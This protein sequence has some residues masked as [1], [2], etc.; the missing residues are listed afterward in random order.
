MNTRK[1]KTPFLVG[2]RN[3]IVHAVVCGA[4]LVLLRTPRAEAE[5]AP[6]HYA[7]KGTGSCASSVCHGSATARAG[8][9]ILHNEYVTWLKRDKHS[10]AWVALASTDGKRIGENLGIA[11]PEKEPLCLT[12][13]ATYNSSVPTNSDQLKDGVGC[14]SCHG[15][16]EGYLAPH[17]ESGATHASNI[18]HGMTELGDLSVRANTCLSCHLDHGDASVNHRLMG[19]GHPRLTFELDTFGVAEPRHW[20]LNTEYLKRKGAYDPTKA[21]FIGQIERAGKMAELFSSPDKRT[22][23]GYPELTQFYCYSCHHSLEEKQWKTRSYNGHPGELRLNLSSLVMARV[24]AH[25]I[26]PEFEK[27]LIESEHAIYEH[28]EQ[29]GALLSKLSSTIQQVKRGL[30]SRVFSEHDRRALIIALV[31]YGESQ[32]GSYPYEVA[33]QIAM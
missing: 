3:Q 14:E 18:S 1:S 24:A 21:W 28:P 8:S 5:G 7:F 10:Q 33:E 11:S 31:S 17:A 23:A 6:H 29:V 26:A 15:A 4:A 25:V 19:A 9:E 22:Y 27:S 32:A 13:H 16:A 20:E 2:S 30:V 12:C